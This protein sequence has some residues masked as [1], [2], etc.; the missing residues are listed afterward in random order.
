MTLNDPSQS[1]LPILAVYKQLL[2]SLDILGQ[3]LSSF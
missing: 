1:E 2:G 3:F